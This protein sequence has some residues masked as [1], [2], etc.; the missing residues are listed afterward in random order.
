MNGSHDNAAAN[1]LADNAMLNGGDRSPYVAVWATL[2]DL[3]IQAEN[4]M[5]D[6]KTIDKNDNAHHS[7]LVIYK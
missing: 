6:G 7:Q 1:R 2:T 4:A 5:I 3:A